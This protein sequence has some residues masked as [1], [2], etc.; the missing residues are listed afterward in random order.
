MKNLTLNS[1]AIEL[2]TVQC[3]VV[4]DFG[5]SSYGL[6]NFSNSDIFSCPPVYTRMSLLL[7]VGI[8][9]IAVIAILALYYGRRFYYNSLVARHR[10]Q[11]FERSA[12][13]VQLVTENIRCSSLSH[14]HIQTSVASSWGHLIF[15]CI[16]PFT[17]ICWSWNYRIK[18]NFQLP[19]TIQWNVQNEMER[20][21]ARFQIKSNWDSGISK[22]LMRI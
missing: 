21:R 19:K 9:I 16:N 5:L 3:L 2:E 12:A 15:P 1:T 7:I 10:S 8:V 22:Y 6:M 4:N 13:S 18:R 14:R 11:R 20:I 17:F